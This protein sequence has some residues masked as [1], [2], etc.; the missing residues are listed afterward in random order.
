MLQGDAVV[1]VVTSG[2]MSPTLKRP[3]A[4]AYVEAEFAL[5]NAT[6]AIDCRGNMLTATTTAL[7]F[8]KRPK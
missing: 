5:P 4:M 8:Y 7:P 1:G 6:F 3:I 2:A